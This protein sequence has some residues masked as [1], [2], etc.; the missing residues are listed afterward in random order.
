MEVIGGGGT[1]ASTFLVYPAARI[2]AVNAGMSAPPPRAAV[3][4]GPGPA[5]AA[6][7]DSDSEACVTVHGR[8]AMMI[9]MCSCTP[10][11][12]SD[13]RAPARCAWAVRQPERPNPNSL[14]HSDDH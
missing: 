6:A 7:A 13:A 8:H 9:R 3:R 11:A 5:A 4:R 14:S 2:A 10:V 1:A 12:A